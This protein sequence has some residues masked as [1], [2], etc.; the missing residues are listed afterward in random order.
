MGIMWLARISL[1]DWEQSSSLP[2]VRKESGTLMPD[3]NQERIAKD[4]WIGIGAV[5]LAWEATGLVSTKVLKSKRS[6]WPLTFLLRD[7]MDDYP[8]AVSP[9]FMGYAWIGYHL[10]LAKRVYGAE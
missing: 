8:L 4:V 10:F 1:P 6:V 3:L 7:I 9:M 5:A 2:V